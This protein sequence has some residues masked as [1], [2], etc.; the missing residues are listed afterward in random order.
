VLDVDSLTSS[1]AGG[2]LSKESGV[3]PATDGTDEDDANLKD[4]DKEPP[5]PEMLANRMF[6]IYHQ[7]N[8]TIGDSTVGGTNQEGSH[9][10]TNINDSNRSSTSNND[11]SEATGDG[12]VTMEGSHEGLLDLSRGSS[13]SNAR[14]NRYNSNRRSSSSSSSH[15]NSSSSSSSSHYNSSS[16][17]YNSSSNHYNSY[18]HYNGY[19]RSDLADGEHYLE[20]WNRRSR[21]PAIHYEPYH[22]ADSAKGG[23]DGGGA[24]G[25]GYG[26]GANN[27]GGGGD[28]GAGANNPGQ[29]GYGRVSSGNPSG[30]PTGSSGSGGSGAP[31][32][33]ASNTGNNTGSSKKKEQPMLHGPLQLWACFPGLYSTCVQNERGVIT[34]YTCHSLGSLKI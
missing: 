17:H 30:N 4:E 28:G 32:A 20:S 15:Y 3:V 33:P 31:K 1:F 11:K 23:G 18:S 24:G 19:S 8:S 25:A 16:S 10:A 21:E 14:S 2:S 13:N 9:N 12:K 29:S 5:S 26:A 34:K 7:H 6:A 27:P 22:R